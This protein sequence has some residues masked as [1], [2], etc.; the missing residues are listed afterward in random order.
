MK[1]ISYLLLFIVG[2]VIYSW[3]DISATSALRESKSGFRLE[4]E[5]S[6]AINNASFSSKIL[7]KI[8]ALEK[9]NPFQEEQIYALFNNLCIAAQE[10]GIKTPE[11]LIAFINAKIPDSSDRGNN[12]TLLKHAFPAKPNTPAV[13]SFDCDSRAF[14]VLSVLEALG[15]AENI[16]M[17]DLTGHILLTNLTDFTYYDLTLENIKVVPS[18]K[19]LLYSNI[20]Y[21]DADLESLILSNLA[22][23]LAESGQGNVLLNQKADA[24][25]M[26][27]SQRLLQRALE[28]NPRN[29]AAINNLNFVI[30]SM[31]NSVYDDDPLV[32]FVK[33]KQDK[34]QGNLQILAVLVENYLTNF[35]AKKINLFIAQELPAYKNNQPK[36]SSSPFLRAFDESTFIANYTLNNVIVDLFYSQSYDEILVFGKEL[37]KAEKLDTMPHIEEYYALFAIAAAIKG[38]YE[39]FETF[40][41]RLWDTN[42][43][44]SKDRDLMNLKETIW[45]IQGIITPEDLARANQPNNRLY[46][47]YLYVVEGKPSQGW[48]YAIETISAWDGFPEFKRSVQRLVRF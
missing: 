23:D 14:F 20:L 35:R 45:V 5:I 29:I 37:L 44:T 32:A 13:G 7:D 42:K 9:P 15:K 26:E 11:K 4:N 6:A 38:D 12:T 40:N 41:R 43:S 19:K 17:V 48:D 33:K 16:K 39:A 31:P 27:D 18:E 28:L 46:G 8:I 25:K 21:K 47:L 10:S 30:T 3:A 22:T 1:K 24:S 36:A 34:A 2:G